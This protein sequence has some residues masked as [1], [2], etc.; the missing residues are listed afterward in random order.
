M[1]IIL[2]YTF[3]KVLVT[4]KS[5]NIENKSMQNKNKNLI[6]RFIFIFLIL[7]ILIIAF[8]YLVNLIIKN[9]ND[10]EISLKLL[11]GQAKV[12]SKDREIEIKN[13]LKATIKPGDSVELGQESTLILTFKDSKAK[14]LEGQAKWTYKTFNND[15]NLYKYTLENILTQEEFVYQTEHTVNSGSAM[16]L[17]L[18]SDKNNSE[19][20]TS[21]LGV[22]EYEVF[23]DKQKEKKFRELFDCLN[24]KELNLENLGYSKQLTKCKKEFGLISLEQ[25]E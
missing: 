1:Y 24:K 19:I 12:Y 23:D 13:E 5:R 14:L 3:S 7:L 22:K 21:V 9:S 6:N 17:G 2:K 10:S 15:K 8:S 16:I 25:L 20:K 18:N 4:Y 11:Q